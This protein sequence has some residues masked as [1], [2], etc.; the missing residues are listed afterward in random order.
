MTYEECCLKR[1]LFNNYEFVTVSIKGKKKIL[2]IGEKVH[3]LT[4]VKLC[5]AQYSK[6]KRKVAILKCDC[7]NFTGPIE[8]YKLLT[9]NDY[10]SCGCYQRKVHSD[11][12]KKRNSKGG[13]TKKEKYK[14][15]YNSWNGMKD[16][17]SNPNRKDAKYYFKKGISICP[18]WYDFNIFKEWAYNNGYKSGLTIDR[19]DINKDY[20]PENCRWI[21]LAEQQSN[22]SSNHF[23]EYKGEIKTIT[24]WG[25]ILNKSYD[26]LYRRLKKGYSLEKI[27]E[28][29]DD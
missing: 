20:C 14:Q 19:I 7:G 4:V 28:E 27:I 6:A 23:L 3:Q 5:D 12:L 18:E 25:R 22:K 26:Y 9:T 2:K 29:L 17:V 13:Y 15:L 10:I 24:E 1:P 11:L 21:T 8:V 16:R